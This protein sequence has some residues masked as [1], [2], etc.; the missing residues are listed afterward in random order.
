VPEYFTPYSALAGG[1]LI[2]LAASVLLVASGQV[3]G[4][5]GVVGGLLAPRAGD[6][7]WRALFL[8]GL[9]GAGFALSMLLP[10][11]MTA[12]PRSLGW[13]AVAGVL[14]GVDTRLGSGC[15][16]GHGV[17]GISRLAPRSLVATATFVATGVLAATLLRWLEAVS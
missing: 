1:A 10:G 8:I 5:S 4:V 9:V 7:I 12:A 17:C 13:V 6:R 16:S 3:A 11:A 14:V 15:T 2:G